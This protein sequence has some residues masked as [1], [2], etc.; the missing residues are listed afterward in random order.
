V[1]RGS[2]NLGN[3]DKV[4]TG[5]LLQ[6]MAGLWQEDTCSLADMVKQVRVGSLLMGDVVSPHIR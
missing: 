1:T 6:F 5:C 2:T 4:N 3:R